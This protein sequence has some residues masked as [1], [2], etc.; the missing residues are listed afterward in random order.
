MSLA[1]QRLSMS[2]S[3]LQW[4]GE[5]CTLPSMSAWWWM[6]EWL[7]ETLLLSFL[8]QHPD[9]VSDYIIGKKS[10][11]LWLVGRPWPCKELLDVQGLW[12]VGLKGLKGSDLLKDVSCMG[13]RISWMSC[14]QGKSL[15]SSSSLD[16]FSWRLLRLLCRAKLGSAWVLNTT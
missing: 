11:G 9:L 7:L 4:T 1:Q 13:P 2:A 10:E 3:A 6:N 14:A 8:N 5:G 16:S 15:L 12:P